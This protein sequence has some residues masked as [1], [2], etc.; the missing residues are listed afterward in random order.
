MCCLRKILNL[1]MRKMKNLFKQ[2]FLLSVLVA[3]FVLAGCNKKEDVKPNE[4]PKE[5]TFAKPTVTVAAKV[6]KKDFKAG[7]EVTKG[8]TVA[9]TA[10]V[11]APGGFTSLE[12]FKGT[13][14]LKKYD[15]KSLKLGT[16]AKEAKNVPWNYF[17]ADKEGDITLKFTA[18]DSVKQSTSVEFKF[19]VK[20]GVVGPV[21]PKGGVKMYAPTADKKSKTFIPLSLP[22]P[23]SMLQVNQNVK[24]SKE[25]GGFATPIDFGYFYGNSIGASF[26]GISKY[27]EVTK[28]AIPSNW[29]KADFKLS[30]KLTTI[31]GAK[32][33]KLKAG[34]PV[35][36]ALKGVKMDQVSVNNLKVGDIVAFS[37]TMALD[38]DSFTTLGLIKITYL[39]K[40]AGSDAFIKFE[41]KTDEEPITGNGGL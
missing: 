9:F 7:G 17:T 28:I 27:Q 20:K 1:K 2:K 18:T 8:D 41:V 11:N 37:S 39:K 36:E 4:K 6:K 32:F 23:Q 26:I 34:K 13:K 22:I 12:I 30:A 35:K 10:N 25:G 24:E 3:V 5:K 15:R 40:G 21:E 31:D 16:G 19:K 14:S 33:D 29:V 38:G